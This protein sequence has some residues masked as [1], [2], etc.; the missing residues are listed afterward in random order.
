LISK[1]LQAAT[2]YPS[3]TVTSSLST[4]NSRR[5]THCHDTHE[6]S[7]ATIA[8]SPTIVWPI[9]CQESFPPWTAWYSSTCAKTPFETF[10]RVL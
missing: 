7:Y 8:F 1:A 4:P 3:S 2:L 9:S 10:R 6:P 5:C